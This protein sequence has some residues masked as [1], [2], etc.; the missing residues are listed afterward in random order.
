MRQYDIHPDCRGAVGTPRRST[1]PSTEAETAVTCLQDGGGERAKSFG[2]GITAIG[3]DSAIEAS[4]FFTQHIKR[5]QHG[6][7]FVVGGAAVVWGVACREANQGDASLGSGQPHN[8]LGAISDGHAT[9]APAAAGSL[10]LRL[11]SLPGGQI[12]PTI[13]GS[14]GFRPPAARTGGGTVG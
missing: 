3:N 13:P 1:G 4:R 7:R 10:Y 12:T 9:D 8:V 6:A 14:A 11:S 2:V 5:E